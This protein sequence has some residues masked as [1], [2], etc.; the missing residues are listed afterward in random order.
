MLIALGIDPEAPAL[1]AHAAL[2][3]LQHLCVSCER[4]S[5]CTRDLAEG[6]A[7]ENFYG[8]RTNAEALDS[9]HV[10]TTFERL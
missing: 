8:Y 10:E 7:A 5:E 1:R 6:T 4:K 2:S 3:E 9:V